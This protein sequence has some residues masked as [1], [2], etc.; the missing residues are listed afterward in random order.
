MTRL[1]SVG[2][3]ANSRDRVRCPLSFLPW[4]S[5]SSAYLLAICA[6]GFAN[7]RDHARLPLSF[8]IT[9]EIF[10]TY[11][12]RRSGEEPEN[13]RKHQKQ[14]VRKKQKPKGCIPG[15][16]SGGPRHSFETTLL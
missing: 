7:S 8:L 3:F 9:L 11:T 13:R 1:Y 5:T 12:L 15:H 2:G 14:E 16:A 4:L 10:Q 6:R